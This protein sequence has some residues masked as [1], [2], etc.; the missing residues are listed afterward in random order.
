MHRLPITPRI[1][2]VTPALASAHNGNGQT[3]RRWARLLAPAYRVT[4]TLHATAAQIADADAMLALH[5]RRSAASIQA[6][7]AARPAGP[8]AVVLTGTDLYQDLAVDADAQRSLA[9][10]D[11][12]VVLNAHGVRAL[13]ARWRA[14]ARVVLQSCTARQALP[15]PASHL[16]VLMVG[17]LRDVKDPQTYWRAAQRLAHR[18]DLR[19]DHIGGVLEPALGAEAGR[20]AA[21]HPRLRWLGPLD[22]RRTRGHIQRA[23]LLVHPSRLEGGAH[24]VIEA[25]RSGTPVLASAIDGNTGLL[26][27]DHPGLFPP[28]DDAALAALIA[29]CRD[30]ASMLPALRAAGDRRA[31]LFA[32]EAEA[33]AL[34]ALLGE[35]LPPQA[36]P[37]SGDPR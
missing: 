12:L 16:R 1:V 36:A 13:P 14:K 24:V 37:F 30:D 22:P 26:G 33:A 29:R 11:R 19:F 34:R 23:H 9:L 27:D 18:A 15:K 20:L 32:P 17:H 10:A 31:G 5:A 6:W 28:G 4:L 35:L 7:R 2:L 8:L 3:A 21:T 25:L